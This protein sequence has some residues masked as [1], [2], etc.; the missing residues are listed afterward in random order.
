MLFS[1]VG[2]LSLLNQF[3]RRWKQPIYTLN[4]YILKT[5]KR[6]I[7]NFFCFFTEGIK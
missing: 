5:D 6:K 1:E 2:M 7:E 3:N 4:Q